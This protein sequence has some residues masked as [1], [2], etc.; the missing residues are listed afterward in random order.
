MVRPYGSWRMQR[1]SDGLVVGG[2]YVLHLGAEVRM[3]QRYLGPWRELLVF[4]GAD[5]V[6]TY[7]EPK[8]GRWGYRWMGGE[9]LATFLREQAAMEERDE[10]LR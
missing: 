6:R 3:A 4:E 10:Y 2:Y 7:V 9:V 8:H 1:K 5:G